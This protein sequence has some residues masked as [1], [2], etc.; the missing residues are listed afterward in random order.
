[1]F[2]EDL[3]NWGLWETDWKYFWSYEVICHTTRRMGSR[4]SGSMAIY[5]STSCLLLCTLR[6][7]LERVYRPL[8]SCL[9]MVYG[10]VWRGSSVITAKQGSG[11]RQTHVLT[12]KKIMKGR[13][14]TWD[15]ALGEWLEQVTQTFWAS[16][17][18]YEKWEQEYIYICLACLT[19]LLF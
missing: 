6:L 16:G 15:Q 14:A 5:N 18:L 7:L 11:Y 1:M 17:F 8:H 4:A 3:D 9:K 10:T 13:E 2:L 12:L 19:K